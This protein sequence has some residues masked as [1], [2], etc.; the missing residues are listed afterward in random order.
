MLVGNFAIVLE[1]RN[2]I[3]TEVVEGAKRRDLA[4]E[5]SSAFRSTRCLTTIR[6]CCDGQQSLIMY[7][8]KRKLYRKAL[9][10]AALISRFSGASWLIC[11][12][13]FGALQISHDFGRNEMNFDLIAM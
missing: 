5:K 13:S 12:G 6:M 11:C 8:V 7:L 10:L 1:K 4:A 3:S 2:V 9:D